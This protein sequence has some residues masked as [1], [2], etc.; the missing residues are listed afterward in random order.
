M[1]GIEQA[2]QAVENGLLPAVRVQ[3]RSRQPHTLSERMAHYK[4]PGIGL[5]LTRT[6]ER[7]ERVRE[8][9]DALSTELDEVHGVQPA[10][11]LPVDP[12]LGDEQPFEAADVRLALAHL[13]R[14]NSTQT[15][16]TET[17]PP[18]WASRCRCS[19]C[20]ACAWIHGAHGT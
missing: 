8:A 18:D 5:A 7:R 13:V 16:Q 14:A 17:P 9:S 3:G 1:P 12:G 2:I 19:T 20:A 15:A 4:V 10:V 11:Q 6:H